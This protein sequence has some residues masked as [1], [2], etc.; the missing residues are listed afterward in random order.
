MLESRSAVFKM[1]RDKAYKDRQINSFVPPYNTDATPYRQTDF[2]LEVR[3]TCKSNA[4]I[5]TG[6]KI[7]KAIF[8][9]DVAVGKT[10]VINRF[11][12]ERFDANYKSTI[13]VDFEVERFDIL[14]VPFNLQIWDTAGQERFKAIAS[15]YFRGAHAIV[16]VFDLTSLMSLSHSPEWL[17]EAT[18]VNSGNPQRYLVGTKRDLMS[19]IAYKEV[20]KY[21]IKMATDLK[22]E[23]WAV[24]SSTGEGIQELFYRIACMAFENSV[25][26]EESVRSRMITCGTDLDGFQKIQPSSAEKSRQKCNRCNV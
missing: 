3:E 26:S 21:A 14:N 1:L 10:C 12:H 11:C 5:T 2:S 16:I 24:S 25:K 23:F 22:A 15:S 6:L 20:E 18:K 13:G 9:G 19:A 4:S 17:K 7:S 8:I